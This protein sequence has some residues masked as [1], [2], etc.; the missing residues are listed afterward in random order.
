MLML[1]TW[2]CI[3]NCPVSSTLVPIAAS[4]SGGVIIPAT[5]RAVNWMRST[6][7]VACSL[8]P[9]PADP[10]TLLHF[11]AT[12]LPN[13]PHPTACRQQTRFDPAWAILGMWYITLIP[14][15]QLEPGPRHVTS[16]RRPAGPK[17]DMR[18]ITA[19]IRAHTRSLRPLNEQVLEDACR[20][21]TRTHFGTICRDRTIG[22]CHRRPER[23]S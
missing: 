4:S 5:H 11:T 1:L 19:L 14:H 12:I 18:R 9:H 21:R 3:V 17:V 6:C 8:T 23:T 22:P 2:L 20:H 10:L 13:I 15:R 16:T 7:V